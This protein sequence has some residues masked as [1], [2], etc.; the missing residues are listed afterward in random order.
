MPPRTLDSFAFALNAAH[1]L[2]AAVVALGEGLAEIERLATVALVRHDARTGLL[3]EILS[4]IGARVERTQI[5]VAFA[6]MPK[7][8]AARIAAAGDFVDAGD[9]SAEYAA[10][11]GVKPLAEGGQLA[12]KGVQHDGELCALV[13]CH[14]PRRIFGTRVTERFAP[15]VAMFELAFA[16]FLEHEAREEAVR[17]LEE[18]TRRT[19]AE[20]VAKLAKL[21]EELVQARGARSRQSGTVAAERVQARA[22]EES[23]RL[24]QR[25]RALEQQV[26]AGTAQLEQAHVELHRRSESLRQ[27]S[28]TLYLLERV[29]TLSASTEDAKAIADGLLSLVGDD[30]QAQRCSL[31]LRAPEPGALYL[32]AA[33]GLAPHIKEGQRIRVGEGVAGHVA[34]TREPLLVVDPDDA[35]SRPL[36]GDEYL[37]TGSFMSFPLVLRG[38]LVG[39]MNVT[40]RA[41]RGL[42]VEEDVERVRLLGYVCALAAAEARLHEKLATPLAGV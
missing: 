13:L 21:E 33:R 29:L 2:A 3:R 41:Q 18:V 16:K 26:I 24:Q 30:L 10:L 31:F 38:E 27:R 35:Q 15:A 19:H 6:H 7:T 28:R 4:P 12:I 39:V 40:N 20:Y 5:E 36:L 8:L 11:L 1:D 34:A 23:R 22:A 37:T 9:Q 25:I 32:A 42:F 17:A 14:E